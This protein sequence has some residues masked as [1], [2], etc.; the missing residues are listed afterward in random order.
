MTVFVLRR[1]SAPSK[2]PDSDLPP[3]A[4]VARVWLRQGSVSQVLVTL[5]DVAVSGR[6]VSSRILRELRGG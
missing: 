6:R 1:L 4:A 3:A 2:P 5:H